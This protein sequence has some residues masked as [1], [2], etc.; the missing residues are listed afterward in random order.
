M[1][2]KVV[3][4]TDADKDP[5]TDVRLILE[6]EYGGRVRIIIDDHC[7]VLQL[8]TPMGTDYAWKSTTHWFREAAAELHIL[9]ELEIL[10]GMFTLQA[11]QAALLI[12]AEQRF[13]DKAAK[14]V[15]RRSGRKPPR[16][17]FEIS[18]GKEE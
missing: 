2:Y 5:K 3:P 6:D 11:E 18:L 9:M 1:T 13:V 10:G 16:H 17:T 12:K 7:Y 14:I 15:E 4:L 8:A